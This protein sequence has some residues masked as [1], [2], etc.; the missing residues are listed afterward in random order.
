MKSPLLPPWPKI[1]IPPVPEKVGL[2]CFP[3]ADID[4]LPSEDAE[5]LETPW[6]RD[7]MNQ[8]IEVVTHHY[9][10]RDNFFVGGDMFL[11]SNVERQKNR[12]FRGPDFFFVWGV[13]RHILR[14][15]Y[16]VWEEDD[17]YPNIIIELL[18]D[19]TQ[20]IDRVEKRELYQNVLHTP[21]YFLCDFEV[22]SL[23]GLRLNAQGVY[24]PIPVNE[25]GWLWSEQLQLWVG[26]WTGAY[27]QRQGI[28][29]RFYDAAEQLV[30]RFDE[31]AQRHADLEKQ[32]ADEEQQRADAAQQ[33]AEQE[34]QRA[35]FAEAEMERLR[36]ELE[37]LRRHSS[38]NL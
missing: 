9:R 4:H 34:K 32:R 3:D 17:R 26:A 16:A 33:R 31:A 35:D 22:S 38:P 15:Y 8:L 25:R 1:P 14:K 2:M 24:E 23:E 18:S 37:Q 27:M 21:E 5:T 11:Y 10:G 29:P 20:H 36:R 28:W 30:P 12:D 19:S 7:A 6:H 13:K